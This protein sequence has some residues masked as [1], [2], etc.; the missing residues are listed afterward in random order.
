MSVMSME[1][2]QEEEHSNIFFQVG[3]ASVSTSLSEITGRLSYS[4]ILI[5]LL[6]DYLRFS[7]SSFTAIGKICFMSDEASAVTVHKFVS[8]QLNLTKE[9]ILN[10]KVS[11]G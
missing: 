7:A 8:E 10:A 11:S 1:E 9:V 6:L 4:I 5:Q 2:S 3:D